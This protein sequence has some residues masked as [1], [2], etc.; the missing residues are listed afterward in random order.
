[1]DI[2]R[3]DDVTQS[4]GESMRRQREDRGARGAVVRW[5]AI[6]LVGLLA[7]P[8]ASEDRAA[9]D[10]AQVSVARLIERLIDEGVISRAEAEALV[11]SARETAL[12]EGQPGSPAQVVAEQAASGGSAVEDAAAPAAGAEP[13]G[14]AEGS[15]TAQAGAATAQDVRVTY[16]PQFVRDELKRQVKDEL[17]DEVAS[18]VT[19]RARREGWGV[20]AGLPD[21]VRKLRVSGDVRVRGQGNL[22]ENGNAQF[23]YRDIVAINAAGGP[24]AAGVD[25]FLNTQQ[26]RYQALARLRLGVEADLGAGVRAG[27]RI[28]TGNA[29][30]PVTRNMPLGNE[31]RT[32]AVLV[33][34]LYVGWSSSG[35]LDVDT[36]A[37]RMANPWM[38][39]ELLWDADLSFEGLSASTRMRLPWTDAVR[40]FATVGA[41]PL[42][43]VELTSKDTWLY[44]GQL[45]AHWA[46]G[47]GS[48]LATSAGYYRYDNVRGIRNLPTSN[49][50][51]YSAPGFVQKGN[52][53]F[54]IRNDTDSNT[55]LFALASEFELVDVNVVLNLAEGFAVA[56]TPLTVQLLG[57]Y[58]R[59]LGFDPGEV[60]ARVGS[61]VKTRNDGY[62]IG[63]SVGWPEIDEFGD[64]RATGSWRHLER[65][66]VLDAYADSDFHGGG[67]DAEGWTLGFEYGLTRAA[68]LQFRYM[69]A[70][71]IDGPP[72]AIDVVQLDL[73]ARF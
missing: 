5:P 63:L 46:F 6:V 4:K 61:R 22:F 32:L 71:E 57:H 25:A 49:L 65:D 48:Y 36:R 53:L 34:R 1:M 41:F 35:A 11:E 66:A 38:G 69:S 29:R 55:A 72:L 17:R 21:W 12:A 45:G 39:S 43:E 64:W 33:D 60:S 51:D 13:E 27:V 50:R 59:N 47:E 10:D 23:V 9:L 73:N 58:V 68:S 20:P 37:G 31:G 3:T 54:D 18:A 26:D 7:L 62:L 52:T 28:A 30:N 15:E 44:G 19:Q 67:T 24:A 2:C 14:E 56:E 8:A 42:R 70:D 16:V 40:G